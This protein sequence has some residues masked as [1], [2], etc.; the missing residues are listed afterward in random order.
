[1]ALNATVRWQLSSFHLQPSFLTGRLPT[2]IHPEH[3]T[4]IERT[5]T[6]S[7]TLSLLLLFQ[8]S[9]WTLQNQGVVLTLSLSLFPG[10]NLL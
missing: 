6:P 2:A 9:E 8:L 1:M 10:S 4:G 3:F 5:I 7:L